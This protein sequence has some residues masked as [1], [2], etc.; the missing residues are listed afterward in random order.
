MLAFLGWVII[1]IAV[2]IVVGLYVI[3]HI[4]EILSVLG[5]LFVG[6]LLLGA[7]ILVYAALNWTGLIA[8]I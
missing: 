6:I 3:T 5:V 1:I 4:D 8:Y 7:G 2:V